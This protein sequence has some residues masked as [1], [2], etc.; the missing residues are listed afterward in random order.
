MNANLLLDNYQ[1]LN[2][3]TVTLYQLYLGQTIYMVQTTL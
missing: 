2:I 3:Y 1:T